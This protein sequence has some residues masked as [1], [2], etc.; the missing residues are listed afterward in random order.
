MFL[1]DVGMT[2]IDTNVGEMPLD[3]FADYISDT[4]GEEWSWIHLTLN[5]NWENIDRF[6]NGC[7]Y[8]FILMGDEEVFDG[9]GFDYCYSECNLGQHAQ[10]DGALIRSS[11]T[12]WSAFNN[13][14]GR[15][16]NEPE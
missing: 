16:L 1:M 5:V 6:E 11:S 15:N 3:I 13:G 10:G 8:S 14:N 12:D 9:D 2:I 4:L 7:G